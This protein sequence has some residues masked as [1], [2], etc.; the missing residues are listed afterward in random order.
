MKTFKRF[1]TVQVHKLNWNCLARTKRLLWRNCSDESH[2][3]PTGGGVNIMHSTLARSLVDVGKRTSMQQMKETLLC[4]LSV[5]WQRGLAW[6]A[7]KYISQGI[8]W[9]SSSDGIKSLFANTLN[10]SSSYFSVS[11]SVSHSHSV[12]LLWWVMNKSG[13]SI[14]IDYFLFYQSAAFSSLLPFPFIVISEPSSPQKE[15]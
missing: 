9:C 10:S 6:W 14:Q 3:V 5:C 15:A 12:S 13:S 11:Q 4:F 1:Y 8:S 7:T 2:S